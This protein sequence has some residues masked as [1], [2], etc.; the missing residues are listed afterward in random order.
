MFRNAIIKKPEGDV[1]DYERHARNYYREL[2]YWQEYDNFCSSALRQEA[3][4]LEERSLLIYCSTAAFEGKMKVVKYCRRMGVTDN[5]DGQILVSAIEG[6][7]WKVVD[8]LL[9]KDISSLSGIWPLLALL[10]REEGL[11]VYQL[12]TKYDL[13]SAKGAYAQAYQ[14]YNPA[15]E[16]QPRPIVKQRKRTIKRLI[17]L[18]VSVTPEEVYLAAREG[19]KKIIDLAIN[20]RCNLEH[21]SSC[22]ELCTSQGRRVRLMPQ[23]MARLH[24]DDCIFS[25]TPLLVALE[26]RYIKIAIRLIEAGADVHAVRTETPDE[27][28]ADNTAV[29]KKS[30]TQFVQEIDD[31]QLSST[32]SEKL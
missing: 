18:K 30:V 25:R 11:E 19:K 17:G 27:E 10:R 21:R 32:L 13:T 24:G 26:K 16:M 5:E 15:G 20:Q 28:G 8:Y 6:E 3:V 9:K 12:L 14:Y 29:I 23:S 1:P 31:P 2:E 4:R 7:Q 22:R